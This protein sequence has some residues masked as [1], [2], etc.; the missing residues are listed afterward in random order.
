MQRGFKRNLESIKILSDSQIEHIHTS[1]I[2]VLEKTG[3]KYDSEKALKLLE[4]NGCLVNYKTNRARIP[5]GLIEECLRRT[6]S[7][8]SVKARDPEKNLQ[9]G[10]NTLYFMNSMGARFSDIDT[11]VVSLPTMKQN[12]EAV[13]ISD[14][15]DSV[16]L[17][18]SYT[19]YF[20][21]ADVP[22]VMCCAVSCAQRFRNSTKPSR[23]ATT[24]FTYL[25]ETEIA[26]ACSAQLLGLSCGTAPLWLPEGDIEA[27]F[28]YLEAGFPM[29][30]AIGGTMGGD[31]P[32]TISGT[33]VSNNAGLLGILVLLQC[34][35][36]NTGIIAD[37]FVTSIN[38]NTGDL[39][40][41]T[42]A[43]SL[44]QMAFNQLW[45]SVYKIPINSV[46]SAFSNS[47]LVDYQTAAEKLPVAV[48]AALS[49]TSMIVLHGG[50]TAELAYN[51]LLAVI[52]DDVAKNIGRIIEGFDIT[53]DRIALD[54]I[55]KMGATDS[56]LGTTHTRTLWKEEDL[57]T[58]VFDKT[59]YNVWLEEGKKSILDNAR[60]RM[61]EMLST[62]KPKPLTGDQDKEIDKILKKAEKFYR[63]KGLI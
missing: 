63:D 37:N 15:L 5:S 45:H 34:I 29:Y 46:G 57:K 62:Y 61:E 48:T 24:S 12:N 9:I 3:F 33:F 7:T 38:M 44:Y 22:P 32:V 16:N 11:G 23:G 10:G 28:H 13:L 58:E 36:P 26:Q 55:D 56:Y 54:L 20:E 1:S 6:P 49:G 17:Y 21:I 25:W 41:G 19:P 42:P 8:F 18:S 31:H 40:F 35:K 14:A 43:S 27:A 30:I 51:P 2:S 47:K 60:E 52:D 53:D 4:K 50:I 59:S 39:D